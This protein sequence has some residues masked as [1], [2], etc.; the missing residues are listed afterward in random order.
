MR[1]QLYC[2]GKPV[3]NELFISCKQGKEY[4]LKKREKEV[5]INKNGK[6][7]DFYSNPEYIR[8]QRESHLGSKN[9]MWEGGI[10]I[11]KKSNPTGMTQQ[12]YL[13]SDKNP[14]INKTIQR[15]GNKCAMLKIRGISKSK[16]H[17]KKIS[18]T[19]KEKY[20]N[21]YIN[22]LKGKKRPDSSSMMKNPKYIKKRVEGLKKRWREDKKFRNEQLEILKKKNND[23]ELQKKRFKALMRKPNKPEK[24]LIQLMEKNDLPYK[25]VGDGEVI[26]GRKNPDFIN[27]N[28]QKKIIELFGDY[29]HDNS[30]LHWNRTE[31][32]T[33]AIY[34]Q[35][36]FKTLIIW[37]NELNDIDKVLKSIKKF[38][39]G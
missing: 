38:E 21:G 3:E 16:T 10:T 22:P 20:R 37:E 18:E 19:V 6:P 31:F 5:K 1:F 24:I 17:R 9:P 35:Y 26:I 12:E 28:G 34:S 29:W 36:G 2:N 13:H 4:I 14:L 15:K 39:S 23:P 11:K 27:C 8:K 25:Y 32:G 30:N 7:C 33:K